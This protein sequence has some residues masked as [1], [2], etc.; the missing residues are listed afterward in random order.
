MKEVV[1]LKYFL[2]L[3]VEKTKDG[4]FLSQQNMLESL[5]IKET[6]LGRL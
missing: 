4:L 3:R 1:V 2:G 5:Q 6:R